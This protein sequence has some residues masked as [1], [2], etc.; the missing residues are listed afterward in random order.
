M[1]GSTMHTNRMDKFRKYRKSVLCGA[2]FASAFSVVEAMEFGT[3]GNVSASMGGAGVALKNPFALYYNPALL[4]SDSKMRIGYS[5]GVG[6]SQSNLDKLTNLNFVKMVESLS[7]LGDQLG[8][9]GSGGTVTPRSASATTTVSPTNEFTDILKTA[10][11]NANNGNGGSSSGSGSDTLDS[12]WKKYQESHKNSNNHSKLVEELKKG[13]QGS[14][15]SQEQ[16]DMFNGFAESVDWS[17]FDVS[18]GKITSMTIKS[19][20]NGA[21]DAA[22]KD[23]DTLFEVLKNNNMNVIS[24]SGIVFQLSSET[25]QEKFGSLAVGLFNTTQAGVSLVGDKSRMRLIFGDKD[26]YYELIV[27]PGGYTLKQSTDSDYNKFSILQSV[28]AGD[29]HKVV[30]SV[31]NLTEVPVGYAYRF[32]FDNSELSIGVAGKLMLGASLYHEQFLGSNLQFNTNFASNIQYN[33]TFGIDLGTYYGYNLSDSGQLGVGFVAKNINTPTF[34]FDTAPTISIKPQYRAGIAY[35]GKRFSLAF[36]ADVLPNEVL[37][38]SQYGLYSQMI[39]GGFKLDYRFVDVRGGVA[40]DLRRD[41]GAILTAGVNIL[42]LIDIAAEVGTTWVD[43]FG[44][45]APK[46]ANVRVGGSF[47]W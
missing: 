44:T 27:K 11:Q 23:L 39:G 30:S 8:G 37:T 9:K 16:K 34:R 47:S 17:D 20:S 13:V 21:L 31:F 6:L 12:L 29:A 46:Y 26:G 25:M 42:G 38:Y 5:I 14:S 22:M 32:N 7:G 36:D 4:A 28:N 33:T 2:L 19:G 43:Y 41:T 40:Y 24:Q 15:M 1:R 35:N 3:M 45:T 10:L 18:N